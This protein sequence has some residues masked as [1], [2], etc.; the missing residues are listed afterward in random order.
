MS[1]IFLPLVAGALASAR[2]SVGTIPTT[3]ANS[4]MWLDATDA[5]KWQKGSPGGNP[6]DGDGLAF[7]TVDGAAARSVK[8]TS[9]GVGPTYKT[10]IVNGRNVVRW[11]GASSEGMGCGTRTL[12]TQPATSN[13]G[14]MLGSSNFTFVGAINF[15][16]VTHANTGSKFTWDHLLGDGGGFFGLAAGSSG[17]TTY[18]LAFYI[19]DGSAKSAI[20]TSLTKN[21]WYVV[22][23]KHDGSNIKIRIN[24]GSYTSTA[25]GS[26]SSTTSQ[27]FVGA[28]SASAHAAT[29]DTTGLATYAALLSDSDLLGV[30]QYFGWEVGITI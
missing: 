16:A 24:G 27:L 19:D 20:K 25:A 10:S 3:L 28:G 7:G 11:T 23:C 15:V 18:D 8:A 9:G 22:G 17:T 21:T 5:T 6:V 26:V 29:V 2:S 30:E 14:T 1:L 4:T 13:L 12:L